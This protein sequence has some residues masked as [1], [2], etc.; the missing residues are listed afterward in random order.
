MG[1]GGEA[2]ARN[3]GHLLNVTLGNALEFC[4]FLV[5]SFIAVQIGQSF[6]PSNHTTTSLLSALPPCGA[7]FLARPLEALMIGGLAV[8]YAMHN[9]NAG[10]VALP[11]A[12][13]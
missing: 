1:S 10:I 7:G 4:Y 13:Q 9:G 12:K 5:F 2:A 8:T 6:F 3:R 11:G